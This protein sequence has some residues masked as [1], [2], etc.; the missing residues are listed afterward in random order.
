MLAVSAALV[1]GRTPG[2]AA[3]PAA[4]T[5][6]RDRLGPRLPERPLGRTGEG[7]SVLGLGGSHV[8][9]RDHSEAKS[10]ALIEAA[11][12]QGIRFFDTAQQYGDGL[13]E[14]RYGQ[15]LTP[16]YRELS[17]VMTK[18]EATEQTQARRDM[19][20][21]R[22][23]LGVDVIDLMQIHHIGSAA[24]VDKRVDGGV[25]DVLL[26]AR[27]QGKIRHLGFTGHKTPSAHLRM[28]ERL[29]GLGVAFDAVQMP[30]N[31]VDP[32]YESFIEHVLP[33]CVQRGCGV[34]AMKT[35]AHGQFN[36]VRST[37]GN[38]D[39]VAQELVPQRVSLADALGFVWSLP[40]A[41]LIS[42]MN[43]VAMVEENAALA[44]AFAPLDDERRLALVEACADAAGPL[45]EFYKK[46]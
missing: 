20:E 10:Q 25:V 32:G 27:E 11:L 23:R 15:F 44:R 28:F 13:S 21:C 22:Q 6:G 8:I 29:D 45:T 43:E 31:L 46:A 42:G 3:A 5:G 39:R 7:I 17:Y 26:E 37:W 14:Q 4:K 24:D 40:V 2:A 33:A 41:S 38:P 9:M 1:V 12:E 35:L 16:K 36:G 19:D 18:T 30:V 34:L